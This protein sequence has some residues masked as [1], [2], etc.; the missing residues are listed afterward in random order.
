MG[1]RSAPAAR[2]LR[3]LFAVQIHAVKATCDAFGHLCDVD[4]VEPDTTSARPGLSQAAPI[5]EQT[6]FRHWPLFSRDAASRAASPRPPGPMCWPRLSFAVPHR[7]MPTRSS[8]T[9]DWRGRSAC[10]I[11]RHGSP[12]RRLLRRVLVCRLDNLI[13]A[14]CASDRAGRGAAYWN[15]YSRRPKSTIL[16]IGLKTSAPHRP[17]STPA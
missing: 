15:Q 7:P 12:L 9:S 10:S 17:G 14:R 1:A 5:A 8:N 3:S 6:L 4:V 13:C 11:K 16:P 2:A